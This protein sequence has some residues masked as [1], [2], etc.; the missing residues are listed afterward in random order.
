MG[1]DTVTGS[2]SDGERDRKKSD[3]QIQ[4]A[5]DRMMQYGAELYSE[6]QMEREIQEEA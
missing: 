5:R 4:T 2:E 3:R 1:R 6:K